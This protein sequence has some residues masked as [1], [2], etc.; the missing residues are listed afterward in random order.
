MYIG[1]KCN[2]DIIFVYIAPVHSE[3]MMLVVDDD[4]E[5]KRVREKFVYNNQKQQYYAIT[6]FTN[7]CNHSNVEISVI[8]HWCFDII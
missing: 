7:W 4:E 5:V 6:C 8:V 3:M 2:C 1:N